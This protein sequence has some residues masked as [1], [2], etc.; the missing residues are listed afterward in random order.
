MLL[1]GA[2]A[3]QANRMGTFTRLDVQSHGRWV[4][5]NLA[6]Q[7]LYYWEPSLDWRVGASYESSVRGVQSTS[8][9]SAGCPYDASGW[10]AYTTEWSSAFAITAVDQAC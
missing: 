7:Y 10:Q 1:Q 2:E 3:V 5:R 8:D 9:D 4:Y 6:R